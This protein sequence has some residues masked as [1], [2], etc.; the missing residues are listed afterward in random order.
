MPSFAP[1]AQMRRSQVSVSSSPPPSAWPL[2]AAITGQGWAAIASRASWKGWATRA[3]AS[4]SKL[5]EGIAAMS[6]PAEKALPAPVITTQR[7]SMPRS[8]VGIAAASPSSSSWSSALREFGR[9]RVSRAT[10]SAGSSRS[11]LPPASSSLMDLRLF[12]DDEDVALGDGLA[13]LAADLGDLARVL[14]LDRHLHLHRFQDD[15][16]VA[17]VDLVADL[18]L[19]LP[20]C[21]GDVRFYVS[22]A[23]APYLPVTPEPARVVIVAAQNE[24]ERIGVAL[25]ALSAAL[26]GA[27]LMVADD[28]STDGTQDEA[29]RHGA[30]LV[31]RRRPHGKGGNVT[32][33]AEAAVGEFGDD[34]TVLLCD[35]DLGESA[36]ELVPL[37]S[38][39]EAGMCDLAIAR[40]ASPEG[41]GFGFTVG[42][43]RKAVERLCGA[44]LDSPLSGQRAMRVST[45]R[46]LIPFAPGWGLE[47]GM[48]VDAVRAGKRVEEIE[49]PLTHRMTGRTP[50]GFLHRASQLRDIRRAVRARSG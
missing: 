17:L 20:D 13:L 8:S 31:S 33:T 42:Y 49:L 37:V 36:G 35:A 19:D 16:R 23:A 14:G 24:V 50:A 3:S 38:A 4:R 9:F 21:A 10:A 18:D 25:D 11:S 22:H 1:R 34:D 26:P 47:T 44:R 28:A 46:E 12:E 45:L 41:G 27:R 7:T 15:D 6:Y 32:A 30:W 43:A 39:V 2:I 48:T 40:F 5:S 29:M